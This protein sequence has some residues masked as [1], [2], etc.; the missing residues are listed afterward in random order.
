MHL[1]FKEEKNRS[2]VDI[3]MSTNF[4]LLTT[5]LLLATTII[6]GVLPLSQAAFCTYYWSSN[7]V[8]CGSV[9]CNTVNAGSSE[10]PAGDYLIGMYYSRRG[11]PWFNLYRQRSSGGYWDYST[12]VPELGCRGGFGLHSGSY[13]LGCITVTDS[14]CFT[15]LKNEINRRYSSRDFEFN[16][17]KCL[18]CY[19]YRWLGSGCVWTQTIRRSCTADLESI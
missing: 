1:Q 13:S 19:S 18:G 5:S 9:T 7:R 12:Q 11:T 14:G 3:S 10:L 15:R 2:I 4:S 17:Y 6:I 16:A 8:R